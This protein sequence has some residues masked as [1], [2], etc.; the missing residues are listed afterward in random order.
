MASMDILAVIITAV[1]TVPFG[2]KAADIRVSMSSPSGTVTVGGILAIRC[3]VWNLQKHLTVNILRNTDAHPE[4]IVNGDEIVRGSERLNMF[5]ATRPFAD[6]S[7]IHFVTMVDISYSHG[8]E[9]VCKVINLGDVRNVADDSV[10]INVYSL[11]A[12][13][14]PFCTS[15]PNEPITLRVHDVLKTRCTSGKGAPTISMEWINTKSNVQIS[16]REYY[17]GS[18][19]HSETVIQVDESF[20]GAIL[21]CDITSDGF[22]DWKRSCTIGPIRIKSHSS[23]VHGKD[24]NPNT[25]S[26]NDKNMVGPVQGGNTQYTGRCGECSS[27]NE[28]MEHYL[29]VA[30]VGTGLLTIL[31]IITTIIMC[32]KYHSI[33]EQTRRQPTR[34]LASQQSV[35]PVYVSLQRRPQST[36]SEREYMTLEDPNN[37]DNKIILPKET[38]DE[39]CRTMTLKRV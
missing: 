15:T 37:P 18:L 25:V 21:S 14:Y 31:F 2:I 3:Q 7:I 10:Y 13:I 9:Y 1:L 17:E 11:P 4:Q 6:G 20:H 29:T 26:T 24:V 38:F 5:L 12:N 35:E 28:M 22:P 8:G 16:S 19:V 32:H 30:T 27:S 33:S 36:Y 39:Y 23:T 34:V